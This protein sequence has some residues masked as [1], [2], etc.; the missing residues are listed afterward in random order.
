M[1]FYAVG[2]I[3]LFYCL[4]VTFKKL[5]GIPALLFRG[6]TMS[7]KID[8]VVTNRFAALPIFAVIMF[9]G[10]YLSISTAFSM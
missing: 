10:Y 2:N 7:D 1:I 4:F 3:K 5:D 8:R 9:L 6:I